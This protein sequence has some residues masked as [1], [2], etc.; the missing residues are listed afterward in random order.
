MKKW[1]YVTEVGV[2]ELRSELRELMLRRAPI[3]ERIRSAREFGDLSENAEY[4]AARQE[5]EHVE[6]RISKLESILQNIKII[7]T[8]RG[9]GEVQL[10]SRVKLDGGGKA[11]QFQVV[12][13][14][15]ADPLNGKISDESPIGQTLL[16]KKKGDQ[17][18]IK[19]PGGA[20][21]YIIVDIA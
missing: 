15:E 10:G 1:F 21:S 18:E 13:T 16:G 7:D 14:L 2:E 20:V 3:A 11:S 6:N 5:Q 9:V 19:K 4:T 8:P 17:V 12:G